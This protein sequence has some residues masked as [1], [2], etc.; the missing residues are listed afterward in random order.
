MIQKLKLLPGLLL[1]SL[2]LVSNSFAAAPSLKIAKPL[3]AELIKGYIV[4]ARFELSNF[5]LKD[6]RG[7]PK[8]V[9]GQGYINLWL[10]QEPQPRRWSRDLPYTFADVAPGEHTLRLTLVGNDGQPLDPTV[11]QTVKFKTEVGESEGNLGDRSDKSSNTASPAGI[12]GNSSEGA[13]A[14]SRAKVPLLV[15]L[16]SLLLGIISLMVLRRTSK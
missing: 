1:L 13:S 15:G 4:E 3:E 5:S 9:V 11:T 10:D 6:Y 16:A 2:F 7:E 14:T 12:L 8:A